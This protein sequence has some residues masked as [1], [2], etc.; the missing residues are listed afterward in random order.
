MRRTIKFRVHRFADVH[1]GRL[2]GY[3]ADEASPLLLSAVNYAL[4]AVFCGELTV[5]IGDM[6]V[7]RRRGG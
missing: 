6:V 1:L 4:A 3:E 7:G 5:L 2:R